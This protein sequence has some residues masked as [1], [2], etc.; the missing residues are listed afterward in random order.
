MKGYYV[1]NKVQGRI[2]K[3][4][5]QESKARQNF[6]KTNIPYLLI[7]TRIRRF[8]GN[9]GVLCFLET[10]LLRLVPLPYYRRLGPEKTA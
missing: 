2:L 8:F 7:H 9:F 5:F 6:R 3:R 4:V 10:P 1:G